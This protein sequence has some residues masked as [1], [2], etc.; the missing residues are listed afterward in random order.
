MKRG[1][2]LIE[3]IMVV[4]IIM[5]LGVVGILSLAN[6]KNSNDLS[7][8]VSQAAALLRQAESRSI[9][10]T[11]GVAWGVHFANATKTAPFYALFYSSYSPTTT[12]GY[13]R[14]PSSVAY[15]TS[16]IPLG[17]SV[18]VLFAQVSGLPA[19]STQVGFVSL[20]LKNLSS[21]TISIATSGAV[22]Y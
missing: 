22:A 18:D 11:Q 6:R 20:S 13:Y 17:G 10:E 1:F 21:S 16:T 4:A 19:S 8:T 5:I 15:V 7:T 9:T 12:A 14:L 3:T 2:T